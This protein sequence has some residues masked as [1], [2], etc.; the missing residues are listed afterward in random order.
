M[1]TAMSTRIKEFLNENGDAMMEQ[2]QSSFDQAT[3]AL[4]QIEEAIQQEGIA[5]LQQLQ[6]SGL[7]A[8][9]APLKGKNIL[10]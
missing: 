9:L 7:G 1:A 6:E 4:D 10:L 3:A 8:I 5:A 2:L